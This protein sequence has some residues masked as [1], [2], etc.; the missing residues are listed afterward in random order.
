LDNDPLDL[1]LV[2]A[3]CFTDIVQRWI[4]LKHRRQIWRAL[5]VI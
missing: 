3:I 1:N 5:I 4:N 2:S